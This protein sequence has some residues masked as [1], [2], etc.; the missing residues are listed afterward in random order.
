MS[1][2]LTPGAVIPDEATLARWFFWGLALFAVAWGLWHFL[3]GKP[4]E[5]EASWAPVGER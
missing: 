1:S 4:P 3:K 5:A 2:N